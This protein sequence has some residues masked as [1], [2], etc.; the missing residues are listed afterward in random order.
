MRRRKSYEGDVS[1][2]YKIIGY[3]KEWRHERV[4]KGDCPCVRREE[5]RTGKSVLIETLLGSPESN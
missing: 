2:Q 5:T 4:S 1:V 3:E